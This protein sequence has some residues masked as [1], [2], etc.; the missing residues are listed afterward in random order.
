VNGVKEQK[1]IIADRALVS[2]GK[3]LDN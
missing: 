3:R 2:L 1:F